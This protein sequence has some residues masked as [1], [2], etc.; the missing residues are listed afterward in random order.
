[1]MSYV[2]GIPRATMDGDRPGFHVCGFEK[3]PSIKLVYIMRSVGV[4]VTIT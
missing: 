1:M 3:E 2:A 4:A